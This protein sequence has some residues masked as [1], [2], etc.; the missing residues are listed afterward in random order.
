L[1]FLL[2]A[3]TYGV[4]AFRNFSAP[5]VILTVLLFSAFPLGL[6][7]LG[8]K[9]S[10]LGGVRKTLISLLG[11]IPVALVIFTIQLSGVVKW[12]SYFS[13][14]PN[15]RIQSG[16]GF[17]QDS[18]FHVAAIQG[19][20]NTGYP[21][22]GQHLEPLLV[23]HTL[24]HYGDAA[25][26]WLLGIDPWESYA[27]FF[28]A[29]GTALTLGLIFFASK[30]SRSYPAPVFWVILI[31]VYPA[32]TATWL[33]I[34]S[35]GQWLPMIVLALSGYWVFHVCVKEKRTWFD[36][37]GLSLLVI[38]FSL[39]KVSI[40]FAFAVFVGLWLLFRKPLDWRLIAVGLFWVAFL[41][42]YARNYSTRSG[43]FDRDEL[44]EGFIYSWEE[45]LAI[46]LV[47]SLL[48]FLSKK[49]RF[50]PVL[51]S[52]YAAL[53]TVALITAVAIVALNNSSDIY[54][55]FHGAFSVIIILM[56]PL[57]AQAIFD[58]DEK[59]IGT[60]TAHVPTKSL[61]AFAGSLLLMV[62]PVSSQATI[63]Q[64][65][66]QWLNERAGGGE[67]MLVSRAIQ[68]G[69]VLRND[70]DQQPYATRL[71]QGLSDFIEYEHLAD[72]SPLLFLSQEQLAWLGENFASPPSW[73]TGLAITAVTGVPLVFSVESPGMASYG[74]KAYGQDSA[75]VRSG[76]VTEELLCQF[77]RPVI[78]SDD[79]E[80]LEFY[81]A[82]S[83][84]IGGEG[85]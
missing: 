70:P 44:V 47:A 46:L 85:Y 19:I 12:S 57:V 40:G 37:V 76:V 56:V 84:S 64:H 50:P 61:L 51:A 13:N 53:S 7:F 83:P 9:V 10:G 43:G 82:C 25:A 54:Y 74:F 24:S 72:Q 22:T 5:S 78:R 14:F 3:T 55:F 26:L 80:G 4:L 29:K 31:T 18:A 71:E 59:L 42:I 69:Q 81:L 73:S 16:G 79:I 49:A 27:L 1:F 23:Y 32:F 41:G 33:A 15:Q 48:F 66:S 28:F 20:L 75:Q 58:G 38:I 35:H 62:S 63:I 8:S 2:G 17:N 60:P 67:A 30:V 45:G 34:G 39:G 77:G 6:I 65:A 36:F 21:T 68:G 52:G 11:I